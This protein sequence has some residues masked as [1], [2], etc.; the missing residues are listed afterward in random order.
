MQREDYPVPNFIR[1]RFRSLSG[2]W[3]VELVG[4]D[5]IQKTVANIPGELGSTASGVG[6]VSGV[7]VATYEKTFTLNSSEIS[8]TVL[9]NFTA[10]SYRS[11]IYLND[12]LIAEN[13]GYHHSMCF[14][15][16]MLVKEKENTLK[17]ITSRSGNFPLGILGEVWLEFSAKSY[18]GVVRS[19]GSLMNKTIYVQGSVSGETEG[20]KVKVEIAYGKKPVAT[21]E[22]NAKAILNL[23]AN[24]KS[25]TVYLWQALAP[26]FY[27]IRLSLF[28]PQGG[29]CDQIYTYCAFRDVSMVDNKLYVNGEP[30]FV[31]SVEVD[32]VYPHSGTMSASAKEIAQDYASLMMLGF[33]AVDF[34]RYPTPRELYVAD[35]LGIMVRAYLPSNEIDTQNPQDFEVFASETQML[36]NR[37]FGHP[38]VIFEIPFEDYNGTAVVQNSI[39]TLIKQTDQNKVVSTRGGDLYSTDLYEFKEESTSASEIEEWLM[40]RF[41][42]VKLSEKEDAKRRKAKPELISEDALRKMPF[43]VGSIKAGNLRQNDHYSEVQ[44]IS[45]YATQLELIMES[46]AIGFTLNSLYD[47][48]DNKNG[49]LTA[50]RDFKLSREGIAKMRA[51]NKKKA[52][53]EQ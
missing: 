43:Y 6:D 7:S 36:L 45:A 19:Y 31:R 21:Y 28:N 44:F 53:S 23:G 1:P 8:G 14:D 38:S 10:L 27:E 48:G 35:K 9:L 51:I 17:I 11:Q 42:G 16:S 12:I 34:T 13:G 41:N 32:G 4:Q 29:L 52:F 47:F 46:G 37:D 49:L 30:T 15:V 50:N 5:T 33:N 25:Q 3:N 40:Y 2:E 22:Y 18:F 20:Y 39:R 24:L 26:R